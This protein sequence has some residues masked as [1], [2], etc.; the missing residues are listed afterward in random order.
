M[1]KNFASLNGTRQRTPHKIWDIPSSP[2]WWFLFSHPHLLF[3]E[4]T[5]SD[6]AA[7][8]NTPDLSFHSQSMMWGVEKGALYGGSWHWACFWQAQN[9]SWRGTSLCPYK[10]GILCPYVETDEEVCDKT[11]WGDKL[12]VKHSIYSNPAF[13]TPSSQALLKT[14]GLIAT[15]ELHPK[16]KS[17]KS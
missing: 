6:I 9:C 17:L 5:G 3:V 11:A 8:K 4:I 14:G 1:T 13:P 12:P 15:R 10:R 2:W 7:R 16:H